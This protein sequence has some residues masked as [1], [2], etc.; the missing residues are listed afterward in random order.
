MS[1]SGR[2][3]SEDWFHATAPDDIELAADV[4]LCKIMEVADA[5]RLTGERFDNFRLRLV[6]KIERVRRFNS[7]ASESCPHCQ[8]HHLGGNGPVLGTNGRKE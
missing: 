2:K 1:E 3:Q 4:A 6:K 7:T 8:Q 5:V